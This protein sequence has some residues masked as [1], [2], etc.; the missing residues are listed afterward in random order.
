MGENNYYFKRCDS[1]A[2]H[3]PALISD[4]TFF[5]CNLPPTN[6]ILT[7]HLFIQFKPLFNNFCCMCFLVASLFCECRSSAAVTS[8]VLQGLRLPLQ[9]PTSKW[10]QWLIH[11]LIL[12]ENGWIITALRRLTSSLALILWIALFSCLAKDVA[13]LFPLGPLNKGEL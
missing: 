5:I 6:S 7:N 12:D 2:A 9:T 11:T 1:C 8:H 4:F 13:P 3:K 10:V